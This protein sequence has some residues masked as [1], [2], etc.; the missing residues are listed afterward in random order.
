MAKFKRSL[1][2]K[3]LGSYPDTDKFIEYRGHNVGPDVRYS[4]KSPS[5]EIVMRPNRT[6]ARTIAAELHGITDFTSAKPLVTEIKKPKKAKSSKSVTVAPIPTVKKKP[7]SRFSGVASPR[8]VPT[9][10]YGRIAKLDAFIT[11][12]NPA[13]GSPAG[14]TVGVKWF[15]NLTRARN[16]VLASKQ[17]NHDGSLSSEVEFLTRRG[18]LVTN[19][20]APVVNNVLNAPLLEVNKMLD[21]PQLAVDRRQHVSSLAIHAEFKTGDVMITVSAT[22][23]TELYTAINALRS[24][25]K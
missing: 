18:E 14:W 1:H 12:G 5:G 6:A 3:R 15:K 10:I 19:V 25:L 2:G 24:N 11:R 23:P 4:I 13:T 8:V 20:H 9:R 16:F 17:Y 7:Q 22:D 21:A